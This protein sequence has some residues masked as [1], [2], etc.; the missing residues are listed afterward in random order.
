MPIR[1]KKQK[2]NEM[3]QTHFT[4]KP[5][6]KTTGALGINSIFTSGRQNNKDKKG[7]L[8]GS[9]EVEEELVNFYPF[10]K[11]RKTVNCIFTLTFGVPWKDF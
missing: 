11:N 6:K 10:K 8:G 5:P 1:D 3:L 2:S 4:T 7:I 9:M